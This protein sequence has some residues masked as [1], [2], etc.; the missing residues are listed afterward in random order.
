ML[1]IYVRTTRVGGRGAGGERERFHACTH[2]R[3]HKYTY[4]HMHA[5][6]LLKRSL[7][8]FCPCPIF[9][10]CNFPFSQWLVLAVRGVWQ[11]DQSL[12]AFLVLPRIILFWA[13]VFVISCFLLRSLETFSSFSRAL[14][15]N[16][17]QL[18]RAL[19]DLGLGTPF[20]LV[21]VDTPPVLRLASIFGAYLYKGFDRAW[22]TWLSI[23]L[24]RRLTKPSR[25]FTFWKK[26]SYGRWLPI[27]FRVTSRLVSEYWII[28]H[29]RK[30]AHFQL[31]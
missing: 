20:M 6:T 27:N 7:V 14:F 2:E 3:W 28:C 22:K 25:C 16:F 29:G 15:R 24:F 10:E 11:K 19:S 17:Q 9:A 23:F 13:S 1:N 18:Q 5:H 31:P 4:I 12:G 21:G 8:H 30:K 26:I